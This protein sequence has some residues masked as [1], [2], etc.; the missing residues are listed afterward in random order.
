[1]SY[2][3]CKTL[4]VCFGEGRSIKMFKV[5]QKLIFWGESRKGD[6][7]LPSDCQ[8]QTASVIH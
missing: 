2:E 6:L 7:L 8:T 1:M 4:I 5:F 3:S